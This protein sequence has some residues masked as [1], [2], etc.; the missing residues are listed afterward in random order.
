M[1]C[2][3]HPFDKD[4]YTTSFTICIQEI[5]DQ[6]MKHW[7]PAT[8]LQGRKEKN[9]NVFELVN[10]H[11]SARTAAEHY[12]LKVTRNG[13]ACCPFHPDK[14]PSMKLDHRFHCFGCGADGDAV[15]YVAGL[16]GIS[17]YE[18]A[19]KILDDFG[20]PHGGQGDNHNRSGRTALNKKTE[21]ENRLRKIEKQF[22]NW[23]RYAEDTL[24][25]YRHL[26][27]DWKERYRPES[28]DAE[29]HPLFVEALQMQALNEYH[30]DILFDGTDEEKLSFFD[31]RRR[32]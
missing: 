14:H 30:L 12:G 2:M 32:R 29:W 11:V 13:M 6:K 23:L 10:E 9:V 16:F 25:K 5:I 31:R 7:G 18:A 4:K 3:Y 19:V 27:D 22:E 21:H 20:I 8:G 24:L 15:N 1:M 28:T 26:L 17:N